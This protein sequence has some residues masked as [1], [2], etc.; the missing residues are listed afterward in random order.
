M[1]LE[2]GKKLARSAGLDT[3]A[4]YQSLS[5]AS[6]DRAIREQGL[7]GLCGKLR[8]I[9]PDVTDQ[10]TGSFDEGEFARYWEKK[11]RGLQAWQVRCAQESLDH[12]GGENLTL[13]DIGD[14]SGNHAAYLNALTPPGRISRIISV[15]LDPVAIEKVKAKGGEAILS[16][17]EELGLQG[18]KCDF[19]MSFETVE[20][21]TDPVRF[22]HDLAG[23]GGAPYLFMS[24]PYRRTSR[25][26]GTLMRMNGATRKITA[27]ETHIYEFS[28]DDWLLMAK[29]AGFKPVFTRT[30]WQYPK[31]SLMRLLAP[32]WRKLDF[33]GFFG[34]LL[35]R[36]PAA[37][38][39][40]ADW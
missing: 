35:E 34:V 13:S 3:T 19:F 14:S 40:Y 32:L 7:D 30:Y 4:L 6:L 5:A 16:R 24:V 33:E 8:E 31:R 25:F 12:I 36:D 20:H 11:M 9:V 38:E 29:F 15:N 10:Y 2:L 22:L 27:E 39:R 17:A 37:L 18:I 28:P 21:L 23:R 1:I 26:G